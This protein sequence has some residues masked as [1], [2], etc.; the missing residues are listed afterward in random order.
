MRKVSTWIAALAAAASLAISPQAFAAGT[1]KIGVLFP[2]TGNA[3]AAG[4]ASKA[5]VELAAEIVNNAHPELGN[6]PLAADAGLP[7]LGGAKL[8]LDLRRSPGQSVGRPTAD[9]APD[10]ARTRCTCCSAPISRPARF[11]A[12]AVARA[13]RHSVHGRRIRPRSTSPA[14]ASNGC[15]ASRRSPATTR[16]TYMR[17]FADMKKAGQ[18]DRFD[19]DR[20]REHR[21][22]HLGRRCGRGGSQEVRTSAVAIRIPYSASSTDVVGRRCCSSRRRIPTS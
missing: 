10:H 4:Q 6:I 11:T 14:A 9:A 16:A 19:R 15:S 8:E 2:L 1:V 7:G 5:A 18:E 3:A 22:R 12:T 17:F 20:Q 13:L 21:L